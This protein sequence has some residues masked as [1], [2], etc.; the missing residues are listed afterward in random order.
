MMLTTDLALRFDPIY[1]PIPSGSTSTPT[2]SPT[3]SPGLVQAAPPRHGPGVALPRSVGT[4]AAAVAGPCPAAA[5]AP[6]G[7]ADLLDFTADESLLG[8]ASGADLLEGKV[9]LP[10]LLLQQNEPSVRSTLVEIMYDG[11]YKNRHREE[12]REKMNVHGILE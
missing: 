10:L 11:N 9:T 7:D 1:G 8:K 6:L 3:R 12:L 4:G 5:G 2:S